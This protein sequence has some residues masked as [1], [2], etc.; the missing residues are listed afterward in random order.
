MPI[1]ASLSL[2]EARRLTLQ[3]Q[4]FGLPEARCQGPAALKKCLLNLGVLQIDSV[5][6]LVRAH[7]LPV[8]SR[9]GI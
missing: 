1:K 3:S 6:V 8:F 9:F 2:D 5:N 4:G 7:Y